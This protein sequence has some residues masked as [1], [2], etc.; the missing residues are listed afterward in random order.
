MILRYHKTFLSH[1]HRRISPHPKLLKQFQ[2]RLKEF[3]ANPQNPLL[4]DHPLTGNKTGQ[5]AFSITGDIRLIYRQFGNTIELY[6]I[7]THNQVY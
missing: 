7:G 2:K 5:R 4:K 6:D 3:L 1:L